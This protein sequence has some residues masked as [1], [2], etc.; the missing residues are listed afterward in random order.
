MIKLQENV[1]LGYFKDFEKVEKLP[2]SVRHGKRY[3]RIGKKKLFLGNVE[4]LDQET[5]IEFIIRKMSNEKSSWELYFVN[6]AKDKPLWRLV[7]FIVPED[8]HYNSIEGARLVFE[9]VKK[10]HR[11]LGFLFILHDKWYKFRDVEY[12]PQLNKV[13]RLVKINV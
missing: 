3:H 11:V 2:V 8:S 9:D 10:G 4:K 5:P 7:F 6:K 12:N 13:S 1:V